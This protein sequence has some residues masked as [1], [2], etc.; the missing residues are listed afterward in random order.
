MH[1]SLCIVGVGALTSVGLN[2]PATAAAVRAGI[3]SFADHPYMIN[4]EGDPYVVAMVPSLNAGVQGVQRYIDLALPAMEEALTPL[5]DQPKNIAQIPVIIGLPEV[6]P[7]LPDDLAIRLTDRAKALGR[8]RPLIREVWT[9]SKGHSAGLLAL[10]AGGNLVSDGAVEFCIIGGV[11][12]YIDADTLD[13]IEDN[14]Q[15]HTPSN[16]WGFVPGEAAAFC[17]ICSRDTAHRYKLPIRAE[18]PAISSAFEENI[19]K[20]KTICIGKGLTQAVRNTLQ[21]LP[22]EFQIDFTICDQ[23]GEAYRADEFGFMLARLSEYFTDPSNFMAP[24]DCWGDVGAASGPLFIH[25]II[26]AADKGYA[27]GPHTLIWTSSERGERAAAIF[28]T[29][30]KEGRIA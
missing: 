22:G 1:D 17:L 29:E 21:T 7:G 19:I 25:L 23:N 13:W 9:L 18:L 14:E 12:S 20:T 15:L 26:F 28:R 27:K 10:E 8:E 30:I 11:D 3:A 4:R 5:V 24:A 16:A 2:A 6:R